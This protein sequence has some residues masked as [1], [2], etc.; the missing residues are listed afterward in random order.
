MPEDVLTAEIPADQ[1]AR[2]DALSAR[3]F[4]PQEGDGEANEFGSQEATNGETETAAETVETP[5]AAAPEKNAAAPVKT[6]APKSFKVG[7]LE[8]PE[9][10]F[11]DDKPKEQAPSET[12]KPIEVPP[13]IKSPAARENFKRLAESERAALNKAAELERKVAE[14]QA[15]PRTDEAAAARIAELEQRAAELSAAFEK[16]DLK[17]HPAIQRQFIEPRNQLVAA[18]KNLLANTDL[19]PS[20]LDRVL[21]LTGK[22]RIAAIDELTDSI[23]SP[24]TVNR[25]TQA[26]NQIEQ[27]DGEM[28]AVMADAKNTRAQL[29][30]QSKAEQHRAMQAETQRLS[31]MVDSV[32]DYF[33]QQGF[34]VFKK[35]DQPGAEKWNAGVDQ[36]IAEAKRLL[37]SSG[38]INE[39]A[40]AAVLGVAAPVYRDM[41]RGWREQA[42]AYKKEL[43]EIKGADPDLSTRHR[44][45]G[46]GSEIP[47]DADYT[48]G[49][50]ARLRAS[51]NGG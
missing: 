36:R 31:T 42:L 12:E 46:G 10:V 4:A 38:D 51:R 39:H 43:D 37:T 16:V 23:K 32:A 27:L 44:T 50:M 1:A 19:D 45:D 24:T 7:D 48:T 14:L 22:D 34:E 11:G 29:D 28:D 13:E 6:D 49:V 33:R 5:P 47:D 35:S 9:S 17:A 20:H 21:S 40:A 41:A 25:L 30:Q 18:T 2:L 15:N 8:I 3:V 26:L